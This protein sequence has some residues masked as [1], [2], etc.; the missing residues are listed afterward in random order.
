[1]QQQK[2]LYTED[3]V[4]ASA[5]LK[6]RVE[7]VCRIGTRSSEQ[8]DIRPFAYSSGSIGDMQ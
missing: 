7:G 4:R 2:H 8:G 3:G 6:G 1:M 5:D